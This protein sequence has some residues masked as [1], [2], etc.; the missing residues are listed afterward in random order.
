[1]TKA[2]FNRV[3][4][5][6]DSKESTGYEVEDMGILYGCAD[7]DFKS[8]SVTVKLAAFWVRWQAKRFDG[9]WDP[10]ELNQCAEIARRKISLVN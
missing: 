1:M 10:D 7:P 4:Q 6:A 5:F 2:E 8:V 9:T 3:F